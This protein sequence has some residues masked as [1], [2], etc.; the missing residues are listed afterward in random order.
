MNQPDFDI[1]IIGGG[2]AGSSIAAYLTQA[3]ISCVVFEREVFPRPH[4][5]ESLVPA[6][7]RVLQE[8]GL[9]EQMEEAKF[10]HKY[11]A[12]WTSAT[13]KIYSMDLEDTEPDCRVDIRF[14]EREMS[15]DRNYTY[16]V[17]RGKFDQILLQHAQTLGA[18]VYEG[19][20]VNR[21]D[22][23]EGDY[24]R[25]I[26]SKDKQNIETCVRLVV[27]ASGRRTLLGTQLKLKIKDP[28]FN[29]CAI[30]TWFEGYDR[31]TSDKQDYIFIHFLPITNT[32]VWQIPITE[33]ITSFGV[34]T[35]KEHFVKKKQER[36]QFFWDCLSTQ[37][38]VFEKLKQ[39]K[40]VR[41][42]KE[43]G[44]YSYAMQQFCG[45]GW[46]L[47]GDAARFVDPIFSSGVSVAL[48]SARLASQEIIKAFEQSTLKNEVFRR[49][50]L[51]NYEIMLRRGTN[52]WY[53]FISLYYRLNILFTMFVDD[54]R[55]RL[56]LV[57]L[58]SGDVYDEEEPPVLEEMRKLVNLVEKN[59]N[60]V[61]HKLLGDLTANAFTASPVSVA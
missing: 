15:G 37:P 51:Q 14:D 56:D 19:V 49:E 44:D 60:H 40:Q 28:V 10:P 58:L 6:A 36:E 5:G 29:Q 41:P 38:E 35:Q 31:E 53:K 16:H 11:G 21:V 4:V 7:N 3:G 52:N 50:H 42:W 33:T 54:P 20:R 43:E 46:I 48:N 26:V 25:I 12:A 24:P 22:F 55:Y 57:K 27:D 2:P 17:D 32:W 59:P 45:D 13:G 23:P 61:W 9:L 18:T 30:H 34:V 39:A 8:L 1:G 47:I